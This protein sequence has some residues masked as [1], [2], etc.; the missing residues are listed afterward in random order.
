MGFSSPETDVAGEVHE[1]SLIDDDELQIAECKA[2]WV[3]L[4]HFKICPLFEGIAYP[5]D[6]RYE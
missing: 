3:L 5:K 2:D 6:N 1:S 4:A